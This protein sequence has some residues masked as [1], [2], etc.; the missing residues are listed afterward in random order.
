[1]GLGLG[2]RGKLLGARNE[3]QI[4]WRNT[5]SRPNIFN[6][7]TPERLGAIYAQPSD[8]CDADRIMLYALVRGLRPSRVLEIGARWGGGAR[9]IS[10]ALEDSGFGNAIGIDPEPQAF[11]PNSRD[12]FGRYELLSGFS[13]AAIP[14]AVSRLGGKI[15]LAFIDAMHTHDHVYA[16]FNGV[17]PH[18]ADGGHV[19]LHDTFHVGINQ[20][21]EEILEANPRF[22][23]CGFLTRYPNILADTTV[24][25]EG[26]RLI[27]TSTPT[28]HDTMRRAYDLTG[29]NAS[30]SPELINWDHYWNRVNS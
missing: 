26:L 20:A 10:A 22:T 17:I 12:L 19:L 7:S 13:P 16:D 5:F 1:M 25:Y 9:I 2:L 6:G 18:M 28:N 21:V 14:E 11:R 4:A 24:A 23:D 15:D 8:M 30:L 3:L 27:R 29:K